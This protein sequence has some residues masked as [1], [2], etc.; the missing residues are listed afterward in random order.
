MRDIIPD[1]DRWLMGKKDVA[2]ATVVQ[3]WGSAPRGVGAKMAITPDGM[4]AGSVSGGC[5]EG[6]VV[7]TGV[8]VLETG[9]PQLLHFGVADDRAWEVGLACGG[10]IEVFVQPLDRALYDYLRSA[11]IAERTLVVVTCVRGPV[12][13][14]GHQFL[15]FD[16]GKMVVES[17]DEWELEAAEE[18]RGVLVAG[19]SCR[20]T[21]SSRGVEGATEGESKT[22]DAIEVF[23]ELIQPPPTLIAV[24][25]VHIAMK[26]TQI[27]GLLGYRT[28]I[29]D[30]RRAFASKVRFPNV[31]RLI[32]EWPEKAFAEVGLTSTTAVSTL[33]H[34]PKVDD[35]ALKIALQSPVFYV[36]ALGS[37]KTQELRRQRLLAGGLS[38]ADLNRLHGPIGLDIGARTPAEI[39]LAVMAQIVAVRSGTSSF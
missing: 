28:V 29:V 14:I 5:V 21:I 3:T 37:R 31:D 19:A 10:T 12:D 26:L 35:P 17:G 20:L 38:E 30:P 13:L 8:E 32:Q 18:A 27:A 24:G 36:G 15:L 7:E 9:Q 23:L 11:L 22:D 25:G 33:T 39:A 34:D 2:L 6:A 1:I 4:F 16:D